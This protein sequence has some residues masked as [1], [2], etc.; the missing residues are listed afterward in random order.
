MSVGGAPR[1]AVL[2]AGIMGSSTALF[3]AR[4]GCEVVLI[5]QASSPMGAASR[6]N[7]GKIHL[8]FLYAADPSTNSAAR[9][10]PGGLAF[11]ALTEELIGTSLT[12][13][14]SPEDDIYLVHP[15]SV[16]DAEAMERYFRCVGDLLDGI[17]GN[18]GYLASIGRVER[19]SAKTVQ[20]LSSDVIKAGFR[21]PERSVC[22]NWVAD[23]FVEA[24]AAEPR[25]TVLTTTKV[26]AVDSAAG[27]WDGPWTI[28][29]NSNVDGHFDAVVNASW[30]GRLAVDLRSGLPPEPGWSHRFRLSLFVRS[31]RPL[32]LPNVVLATG[33]FGDIK[34]YSA[35]DFYLSWYPAG[36]LAEG[37]DVEPPGIASRPSP[38]AFIEAV[39][40]GLSALLPPVTG[41]FDNADEI[42][43]GGGW[44]FA[45]GKGSLADAQ[46]SLHRRD[47]FGI[48]R[49]GTY[50]SVDTGKYSTAPWLARH[51]AAELAAS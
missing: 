1:V 51:V 29:S 5:D 23:R 40:E 24:L 37:T 38:T 34:N 42:A 21:V 14:I 9:M 15:D 50:I 4:A 28:R 43:I 10:I 45:R 27:S 31:A 12:P 47:Q 3:L 13:A 46:A 41:I 6:W 19:L 36:L 25:I 17:D 26:A 39:K 35:H 33:P 22:T 48:K 20:A 8:G 2:G 49:V 7:E 16:V 44:V 18:S 30:E 32:H 11:K